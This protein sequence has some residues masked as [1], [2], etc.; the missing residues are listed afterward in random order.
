VFKLTIEDDEGK[1][2]VVP[3]A[4]DEMTIGR[5]DGNTIRLT[6]RNVSRRHA[7]LVRQNGALFIE[8][9]SSFTGVRVNGTKIASP[10]P[11]R[12]G[13]EV[14]IGDYRLALRGEKTAAA[15]A[16]ADRPTMPSMP[17][18]M[19]PM[20]TLGG[21]V[22]IP[23]RASVAAM[24]AAPSAQPAQPM[25]ASNT[26]PM[27]ASSTQPLA[28]RE[29]PQPLAAREAPRPVAPFPAAAP[30]PLAAGAAGVRR[31]APAVA[32]VAP[33]GGPSDGPA[34][35]ETAA[36][37]T[38]SEVVPAASPSAGARISA[39]AAS[40]APEVSEAQP[41]IPIRTLGEK[42]SA[43]P[44]ARVFAITTDLAGM[45]FPLDR[46]SLVIGR[47]DENDIVLN[48]RS[49]SR[50]HAKIVRDGEHYTIVD[51]QSANGVRVNGEDYERIELNPGDVIEL[52]HVKL[53]FVGANESFAFDSHAVGFGWRPSPRMIVS[54]MFGAVVVVGAIAFMLRRGHQEEAP[55]P[56]ATA[57]AVAPAAVPAPAPSAPAAPVAPA[58]PPAEPAAA[59]PPTP[60]AMLA[61]ARQAAG[62]EDWDKARTALDRLGTTIA[63]PV[64][65][66]DAIGLR[67]RVDTERQAA[68]AFAQ[69]DE[70]SSAKNY[71]EALARYQE[72]PPD[73][74]YKKRARPRYDD[75]R[76]LVVAQHL[77]AAEKA[78]AAGRCGDVR[79]ETDEVLRLEPRNLLA[80]DMVRLC[81][82]RAEPAVTAVAARPARP[83]AST[84]L[85]AENRAEAAAK[86]AE[87]SR[88]EVRPSA[89]AHAEPAAVR[90]APPAVEA[91]APDPDALM[92]QAREAWLRQQCGSAIDLSRK[93]LHVKPGMTDAY[94]IIA[95]CSCTLKDG[96]AAG[97]AYAKLDDKN[98]NLVHTL[99]QKNGISV[100]E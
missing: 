29:A 50:H 12:E 77:G 96:E 86:R 53:R 84:A 66:R 27:A 6:E 63:D 11:L 17:A 4:R 81:R 38:G 83:R 48:H 44:P 33:S 80:K 3:L 28:A 26:Q 5:L 57:P 8:D 75:A 71:T 91:D 78:R 21:S 99:C 49:I 24:S 42:G 93:A 1:T 51:L 15:S 41:T 73:S 61:D 32:S 69:F 70:A 18:T 9:L 89:P 97:R 65:R 10:T 25:A 55:P 39:A 36:G 60:A 68:I 87:A 88:A 20:A 76:T 58:P 72:I 85:S 46:P 94:Q 54:A 34:G 43:G 13:D 79:T 45:E 52:G 64:V 67:R 56:I 19:G 82:P 7:R 100:G 74:I 47:T 59:S 14:Q 22:A 40:A 62:A 90:E 95:V 16:V 35:Q 2:T 31:S 30:Q 23:T 92:K 37:S 98:R